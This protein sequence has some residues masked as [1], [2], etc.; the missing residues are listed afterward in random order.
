MAGMR[1]YQPPRKHQHGLMG[2]PCQGNELRLAK[3]PC[4]SQRTK[5]RV[6]PRASERTATEIWMRFWHSAPPDSR[7]PRGVNHPQAMRQ[8]REGDRSGLAAKTSDIHPGLNSN[9]EP[10]ERATG[11]LLAMPNP[12]AHLSL[13]PTDLATTF[14]RLLHTHYRST[15]QAG[16]AQRSKIGLFQGNREA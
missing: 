16:Y 2:R 10:V 13:L 15:P 7:R 11:R 5:R 1:G 3:P 9:A 12:A 4:N 14:A 8:P 6:T